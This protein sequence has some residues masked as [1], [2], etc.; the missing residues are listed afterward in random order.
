[1]MQHRGLLVSLVA[2]NCLW[3]GLEVCACSCVARCVDVYGS[4]SLSRLS[5]YDSR[6]Q[7][8]VRR[9]AFSRFSQLCD[10]VFASANVQASILSSVSP[11]WRSKSTLVNLN[12]L[13]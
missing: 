12:H 2:L 11:A 9:V 1:M 5:S 13:L 7:I 8:F 10:L 4:C 3:V 6:R